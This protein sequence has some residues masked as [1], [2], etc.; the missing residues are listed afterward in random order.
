MGLNVVL[1]M[2]YRLRYQILGNGNGGEI[3]HS[4]FNMDIMHL[5]KTMVG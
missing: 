5:Q 3:Y 1:M 2:K 4:P